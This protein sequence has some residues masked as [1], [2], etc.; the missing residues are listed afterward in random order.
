M[1]AAVILRY[2]A[3]GVDGVRSLRIDPILLIGTG[4]SLALLTGLGALV[5]GEDFLESAIWHLDVP[6]IGDI[7]FVTSAL[8]DIGVH[9]LVVGVVM[10][11]LVAFVEADDE[12]ARSD[13]V[14][15]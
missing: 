7:K 13:E 11:I 5:S 12:V 9:I 6:L 10:S 4:L 2:L 8:F 14:A 15:P 3:S 1:G